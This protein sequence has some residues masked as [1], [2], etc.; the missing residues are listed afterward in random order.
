MRVQHIGAEVEKAQGLLYLLN[1]HAVFSVALLAVQERRENGAREEAV[2]LLLLGGELGVGDAELLRPLLVLVPQ[3]PVGVGTRRGALDEVVT[4]R[5]L[6]RHDGRL[7]AGTVLGLPVDRELEV[8]EGRDVDLG[9][10]L[11]VERGVLGHLDA[12]LVAVGGAVVGPPLLVARGGRGDDELLSEC[13]GEHGCP[14][15]HLPT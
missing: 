11:R 7:G 8:V 4:E 2:L 13:V 10:A 15:L 14:S 3:H 9:D 5:L 1:F 12:R 6:E